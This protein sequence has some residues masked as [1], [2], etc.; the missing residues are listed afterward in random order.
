[1]T[2]HIDETQGSDERTA[3]DGTGRQD[4]S[5]TVNHPETVAVDEPF[6]V[7]IS[8]IPTDTV[9]IRLSVADSQGTTWRA[10]ATY[11]VSSDTL[12]P[13]DEM[14]MD[15]VVEGGIM[16]L[17]QQATPSE[18]AGRYAVDSTD[19]DEITLELES[20]GDTLA[21]T[22]IDR[23][24]GNPDVRSRP[25]ESK[26]V[27]GTVF[28]PPA[29]DSAPAVVV[30]H[31][32]G[33]R[34]S[35]ATAQLLASHGFVTM[36]LQYFDWQGRHDILPDALTE[37]PLRFVEDATRWLLDQD[38]VSGSR[39]GLWGASKGGEFALLAG[40]HLDTVGP[41]VS[42]NG[43]G[44]VWGGLSQ[45]G[46]SPDSSWAIDDE[47]VTQVP[48]TDD[49]SAWDVTPP[50]E[51]EPGYSQSYEEASS[52]ELSAA[53][54]P[55]EDIDGPVLLVAGGADSMWDSVTLGQTAAER[56]NAHDCDY[57]FLVYEDAGHAITFPYMPTANR[58]TGEQYVMGGTPAGYA[59]ADSDHWPH[60]IETFERLRE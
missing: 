4:E 13:A 15:G 16:D 33:G 46:A 5:I 10:D 51:N 29:V 55:V 21:T 56:L 12:V 48:Y 27:V 50:M 60:V 38:T 19:C 42:V 20:D 45:M 53:E 8:G 14:S 37:V 36:A 1:M 24:F 34:P 47:P 17:L 7:E 6:T 52:E 18:E 2:G 22:T 35:Y 54:I 43:S 44:L 40:S 39:V 59:A 28:E 41:V 30:L 58:A 3:S 32:S 31:G 11:Y 26:D 49:M 57:E 9:E 23:T 25:V